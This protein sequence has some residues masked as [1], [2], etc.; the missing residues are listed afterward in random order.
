[1]LRPALL[2]GAFYA[3]I[4][5]FGDV[6]VSIFLV[7]PTN[8][9]LPVL[10]FQDMRFDFQP[11]ILAVSTLVSIISMVL[12]VGIQKLAGL[13]MVLPPNQRLS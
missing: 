2:A 3:F 9:T 4:I 6:P 8:M 5:S 13:D 7:T 1:M 11:S 10:I 12:I